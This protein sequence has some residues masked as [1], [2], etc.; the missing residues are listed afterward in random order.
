VTCITLA[1]SQSRH[2]PRRTPTSAPP[3]QRGPEETRGHANTGSAN[4]NAAMWHISSSRRGAWLFA[5]SL[6]RID[7]LVLRISRG[8]V[9]LTGATGGFRS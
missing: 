4:E 6:P 9:T 1:G 7:K 5:R 8:Q 2:H 3:G